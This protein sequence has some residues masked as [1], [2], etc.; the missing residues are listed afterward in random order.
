MISAQEQRSMLAECLEG[1]RKLL[2]IITIV[3]G[4]II[5]PI[6]FSYFDVEQEGN[7]KTVVI[8]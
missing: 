8:K 5:K 6:R 3:K 1:I 7:Y 2:Q 4:T